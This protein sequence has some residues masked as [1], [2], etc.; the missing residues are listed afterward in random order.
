MV[1]EN[2]KGKIGVL[3]E[4][5]FDPTEYHLFKEVF[6]SRGYDV[7]LISHLW[8]NKA[9]IEFSSNPEPDPITKRDRIELYVTVDKEV[10]DVVLSDYKGFMLIGAYAMDRLRY[11]AHPVKGQPNQS[12]AV[13][14]LRKAMRT[15]GLKIGTICH[16][17]WLLCADPS[18]L[19]GRKVTCSNNL[20]YD[21]QNAGADVQ[22]GDD[23]PVRLFVDGDLI[24]ARHPGDG[25]TKEFI[26]R[27]IEEIER[28]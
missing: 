6:P 12:P 17:L 9:G 2:I 22:F 15:P 18:L 23:G 21:V 10:A 16:S 19:K 28:R 3:I 24:S 20:I 1:K 4:N 25:I 14:F 7:D 26:E 13:K 11:E 27:F 5:H 8:G